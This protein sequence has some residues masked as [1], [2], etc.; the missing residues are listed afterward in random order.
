MGL[1]SAKTFDLTE[2]RERNRKLVR[3]KVAD[4]VDPVGT[5]RA[6]KAARQAEAVKAMIF[7]EATRRFLEQHNAKWE[8]RKRRTSGRTR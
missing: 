8:S 2:A 6:D 5:R 7:A 3:Q 1:G 4:G